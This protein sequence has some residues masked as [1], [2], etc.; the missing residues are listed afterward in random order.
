MSRLHCFFVAL[1][2]RLRRLEVVRSSLGLA[3]VFVSVAVGMGFL[4]LQEK[5]EDDN[6]LYIV[7]VPAM[8]VFGTAMLAVLWSRLQVRGGYFFIKS[9][10]HWSLHMLERKKVSVCK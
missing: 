2:H 1:L 5:A 8:A 9:R 10:Y 7:L 6:A 3:I 4:G